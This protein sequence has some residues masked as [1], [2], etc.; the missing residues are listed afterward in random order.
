MT[1]KVIKLNEDGLQSLIETVVTNV[2][3]KT[4]KELK[5]SQD[6]D[7]E[8]FLTS[9]SDDE[10]KKLWIDY[11][12]IDK[13]ATYANPL[14]IAMLYKNT[15]K[16]GLVRTYPIEETISYIKSYFGLSDKQIHEIKAENG[17][18][19]I[20]VIIPN[21]GNNLELMKQAMNLCGYYLGAPK[22][23]YL[24]PN[25]W[26]NL[27][28]EP[29]FQKDESEQIRN[30]ESVLYHITPKYNM[31]KIKNIGF[32]PKT[33]NELFNYPDRV[34]FLRGSINNNRIIN[35]AKQLYQIN[36]SKGNNGIYTLF[37][38]DVNKIPLDVPLFLDPNYP[39]GIYTNSNISP[40]TIISMEEINLR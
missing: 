32:S 30:E 15:L 35:I 7:I 19:H 40:N 36:S 5:Y 27:Q 12:N 18:S 17:I 6:K 10:K 25:T 37:K 23:K 24:R 9:L 4:P 39:Y 33:K 20:K 1:K 26:V 16:E 22:E 11:S 13:A 29:K 38:V 2:L 31:E 8:Q 34:Y 3:K 28:F 21:I 14:T